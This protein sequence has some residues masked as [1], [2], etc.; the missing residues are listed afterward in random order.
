MNFK[1]LLVL[2]LFSMVSAAEKKTSVVFYNNLFGPEDLEALGQPSQTAPDQQAVLIILTRRDQLPGTLAAT[3]RTDTVIEQPHKEIASVD[4]TKKSC[5]TGCCK[6][7][8]QVCNCCL[9][10][11]STGTDCLNVVVSCLSF[12]GKFCCK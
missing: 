9:K 11:C 12:V 1:G 8:G 2:C 7:T 10:C 3:A 6:K 4:Q 5:C